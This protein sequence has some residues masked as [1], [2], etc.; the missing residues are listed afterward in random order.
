MKRVVLSI[1]WVISVLCECFGQSENKEFEC[2]PGSNTCLANYN[3]KGFLLYD[4]FGSQKE[5][6]KALIRRFSA[7]AT[8]EWSETITTPK[9]FFNHGAKSFIATSDLNTIYSIYL[10]TKNLLNTFDNIAITRID[11]AGGKKNFKAKLKGGPYY[12]FSSFCDHHYV[13]ALLSKKDFK[14][15]YNEKNFAIKEYYLFRLDPE[16]GE[17]E[18]LTVKLPEIASTFYSVYYTYGGCGEEVFYLVERERDNP[19]GYLTYNIV[20]VNSDAEIVTTQKISFPSVGSILYYSSFSNRALS[21]GL[22]GTFLSVTENKTEVDFLPIYIDYS[23]ELIYAC[24]SYY[25]PKTKRAESFLKQFSIEGEM[26]W[27]IRELNTF[28]KKSTGL[29][30]EDIEIRNNEIYLYTSNAFSDNA[31]VVMGPNK[32]IESKGELKTYEITKEFKPGTKS[33]FA[34]NYGGSGTLGA[35]TASRNEGI[36]FMIPEYYVAATR[37]KNTLILGVFDR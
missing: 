23:N 19:P 22:D 32:K 3:E 16:T 35:N 24:G 2:L 10:D 21:Y 5:D 12:I 18:L 34:R 15:I 29:D 9:G 14:L 17:S 30:I 4:A 11:S 6:E 1:I 36:V 31:F 8:L 7:N 33:M 37:S 13:Y 27:E 20:F 26:N 25:N 28:I